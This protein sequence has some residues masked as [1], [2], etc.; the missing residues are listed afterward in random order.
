MAQD[1]VRPHIA[2]IHIVVVT[3]NS[4]ALIERCLSALK[5]AAIERE[6]GG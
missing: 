5:A 4:A 6:A 2:V 3:Y 1:R